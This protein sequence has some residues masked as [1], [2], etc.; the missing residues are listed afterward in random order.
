[1]NRGIQLNLTGFYEL[2]H[3]QGGEGLGERANGERRLSSR[4]FTARARF[5]EAVQVDDLVALN[6]REGRTWDM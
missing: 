4:R 6:D 5:A 2:H 1:L 3:R